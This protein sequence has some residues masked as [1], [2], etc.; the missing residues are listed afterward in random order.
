MST[1][2]NVLQDSA[3]EERVRVLGFGWRLLAQL[4]DG[5]VIVLF[6]FGL[7]VA[8]FFLVLLFAMFDPNDPVNL[9]GLIVITAMIVSLIY[10]VG[11]WSRTGQTVGKS[12]LGMRIVATD[13]SGISVGKAV[14][15]YIGYIISGLVFSIGFLWIN[16]SDKRQGWHDKM[17]GT[18]VIDIDD[19]FS[20]TDK[21]KIIHRDFGPNWLWIVVWLILAVAAPSAL[22]ASLRLLSPVFTRLMGG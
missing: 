21:I 17:A 3:V 19:G 9:N 7:V 14:L 11:A 22:F 5:L 4:I 6:T 12:M 2:D 8:L 13:G 1:T 16:F 15:R 20:S 18:Y 10:Y